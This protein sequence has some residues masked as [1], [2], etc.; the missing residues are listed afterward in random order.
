MKKFLVVLQYELKEYVR[1]KSFVITTLLFAILGSAALFLPRVIDMSGFLGTQTPSQ[2]EA[3][4]QSQSEEADKETMLLYDQAGV[5]DS[6]VL[7]AVFPDAQWESVTDME[8]ITSRIEKQEADA[9]FVV[10][11][12]KEYDYY[13]FN[14]GMYDQDKS[15]FE[16][17][18]GMS[19]RKAYCEANGLDFTQLESKVYPSFTANEQVLGKDTTSNYWYCYILVILVFMLIVFYGQMIAVAVTNEKSNRSI[20]VLVTTTTPNSLLF[21]KVIA[22]AIASL[23]QVGIILGA[24]LLSYQANRSLWGGMLDMVFNIP[25]EVLISFAFFGLGGYLFYA[26]L[27]GAMGALVSKT[28]DISKSSGGLMMV[29]MIVYFIAL[30]QLTNVDGIAMK[31]LSFLPISS[32]SAMFVRI[33]MGTVNTWEIIV[34][35]VI[36]VASIFGAGILGAKIYR[37][38]TLR[39]GKPIKLTAAL[40]DLKKSE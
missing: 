31:V 26:F 29:V 36:L 4:D 23:C 15:L 22:G 40:K 24:V 27:Y 9:A 35:F 20:E 19:L 18:L 6:E 2:E 16:T 28:E 25:A 5:M 13:V 34:S 17:A 10:K 14:K 11:S 12:E 21:G 8:T 3:P 33:A 37:M 1:N 39:Y 32:Y 30:L 38:G 7:D